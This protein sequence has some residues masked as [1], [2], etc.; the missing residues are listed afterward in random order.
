M[1]T[2]HTLHQ[3]NVRNL[4]SFKRLTN[5]SRAIA[6]SLLLFPTMQAQES[7]P[8]TAPRA[9][10]GL[11]VKGTPSTVDSRTTHNSQGQPT[12]PSTAVK[13]KQLEPEQKVHE[14]LSRNSDI[15]SRFGGLIV[16]GISLAIWGT[17]LAYRT[18]IRPAIEANRRDEL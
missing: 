11:R 1:N 18:W 7:K 4:L 15:G 14:V 10:T 5:N 16:L 9:P 3:N 13:D 12:S 17:A 6:L 2:Q 8:M